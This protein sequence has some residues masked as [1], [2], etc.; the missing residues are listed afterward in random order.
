LAQVLASVKFSR[1]SASTL[2]CSAVA[3]TAETM[4][5]MFSVVVAAV[6]AVSAECIAIEINAQTESKANPIRRVVSMLQKI[7]KKVEKEGEIETELHEA[8][9]CK[10]KTEGAAYTQS[11]SD[12]EA[13]VV[14]LAS[15]LKSAE[16]QLAQLKSD[17]TGHKS[18]REA[19]K[20][21]LASA[22]A[23]REKEAEAFAGLKAESEANIGAVKKAVTSIEA[24]GG[25][26]FLQ[27]D[28]AQKLHN[29][30]SS[31]QAMAGDSRQVI[32][33]FLD[34]S[35]DSD[36]EGV[37]SGQIVGVLKQLGDEM[38]KDLN[39]ATS[40]ENK[41]IA[42]CNG[43]TAAKN[44]EVATLTSAIE[45]KISR[46]GETGLLIEDTKADAKDTADKLAEDKDFLKTLEVDCAKKAEEWTAVCTE[47]SAELVALAETITMLNSDDALEL[48]KKTL[49]SASSFMQI[50]V[51]V[52][53]SAVR[54]R[55]LS[56]IRT[57]WR[58]GIHLDLLAMAL[59]GKT[60]DFAKVIGMIDTMVSV[61][62]KEQKDDDDK[63]TYCNAEIDTSEDKIKQNQL[64]IHDSEAAV[65]DAKETIASTEADITALAAGLK[66][67][68]ASVDEAT[69]QRQKENAAFKELRASNAAAKDLIEMAKNRLQQFYNPKLAKATPTEA[70]ASFLQVRARVTVEATSLIQKKSEENA[71]VIASLDLLVAD[72]DKETTVA[73]AEEKDAQG[74][75]QT[76]MKDSKKMRA[77]NTRILQDKSSAKADAIGAL[78]NHDGILVNSQ[79]ELMGEKAHLAALHANC[80][81]LVSNFDTR[82]EARADEVDS[83]KN[84]KAVLSGAS[85]AQE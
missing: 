13:K 62:K 85:L 7:Q 1:L 80:D 69:E 29:I 44:S 30:A 38:Q 64:D 58:H 84:A 24:G 45:D 42:D 74:D 68:D 56:M 17:L 28:F 61:L 52:K 39:D 60:S 55:V 67:L 78:E 35:E 40:V 54:A 43:L 63:I 79:K 77:D 12:G 65:E 14:S 21:A 83:L 31:N 3:R 23:L 71:G 48:F 6:L 46:V 9:M 82:K 32:L 20:Q 4:A 37:G 51:S 59:H 73:T 8:F 36:E 70:P 25:S 72:L 53:V 41:A 26:A 47:R 11:I 16:G 10:C 66:E 15:G 81:W 50:Q 33:S 49:P 27:T 76:L 2:D 19:A 57:T 34:Q 5:R 75:Y 22:A 18:D